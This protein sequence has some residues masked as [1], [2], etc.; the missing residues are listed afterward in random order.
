MLRD[1]GCTHVILGHSE[2]RHGLGETDA[3]VNGKAACGPGSRAD[4]II[5]CVGETL[6][7]RRGGRDRGSVLPPA[8]RLAGRARCGSDVALVLAYEPVWAIGTGLTATPAQAQHAHAFIRG[9]VGKA[10]GEKTAASLPILY[11]GSVKA[12]NARELFSQADVDGG[13][14]GGASLEVD[15]FLAIARAAVSG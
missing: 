12:D 3:L 9:D 11:G 7:E 13:L 6:P 14:I 5:L 4:P 15:S 2:R 10:L 8:R 1:V